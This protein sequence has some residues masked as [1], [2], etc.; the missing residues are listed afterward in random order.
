MSI[1]VRGTGRRARL[2]PIWDRIASGQEGAWNADLAQADCLGLI[3][4]NIEVLFEWIERW[5]IDDPRQ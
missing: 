1:D 4:S 2:R 5:L 3:R